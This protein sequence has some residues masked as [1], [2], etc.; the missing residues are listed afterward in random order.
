M[1]RCLNCGIQL[2]NGGLCRRC[3]DMPQCK[4]CKRHLP[5]N[6]FD[7]A[8]ARVC[9]VDPYFFCSLSINIHS[10]FLIMSCQACKLM[11]MWPC[12]FVLQTCARKR[13]PPHIT[14]AVDDIV[15]EIELEPDSSDVSFDA[16]INRNANDMGQI[17]EENRQRFGY[18]FYPFQ[19]KVRSIFVY[20]STFTFVNEG[21]KLIIVIVCSV[22]APSV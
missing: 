9:Q 1:G 2:S 8:R 15:G 14:H 19:K 20:F 13:K 16:F 21:L 11:S 22:L 12:L 3:V 17:I 5:S 6:C 7:N 10:P 4:L 18:V